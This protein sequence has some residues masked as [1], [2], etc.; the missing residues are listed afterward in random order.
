[1]EL[2]EAMA[3]L[4][5]EDTEHIR[6]RA[7]KAVPHYLWMFGDKKHRQGYCTACGMYSEKAEVPDFAMNDP[8]MDLEDGEPGQEFR[9][10]PHWWNEKDDNWEHN[11]IGSCPRC[12]ERVQYKHIGRGHRNMADWIFLCEYKKSAIDPEHT[13]CLVGY[14]VGA[15]HSEAAL[16]CE[17]QYMEEPSL[18]IENGEPEIRLTAREICIFTAGVGAWRFVRGTY[19]TADY[20]DGRAENVQ[21]CFAW[22][23]RKECKSG[24][25]AGNFMGNGPDAYLDL[26]EW[27]EAIEGTAFSADLLIP[28]QAEDY[29]DKIDRMAAMAKYPALEYMAKMGW[30][31][32]CTEIV[33]GKWEKRRLNLKAKTPDKVLKCRKDFYGWLKGAKVKPDMALI[34]TVQVAEKGG[35]RIGYE[36]LRALAGKCRVDGYKQGG[37]GRVIADMK[38][39]YPAVNAEQALK[40]MAR[41]GVWVNDYMDHL[42]MMRTL[43]MRMDESE[44]LC[45][46][47]FQKCH[48]ELSD[49]AA[50]V[51][52]AEKD[53]DAAK[54]ANE[55]RMYCFSALGYTMRPFVS[56]TEITAEGNEQHICIGTYVDKYIGRGT[57]I[58]CIRRDEELGKPFA[59][60]EFTEKDGKLVQCRGYRNNRPEWTEEEEALFWRLFEA[61]RKDRKRQEKTRRVFDAERHK[62]ESGEALTA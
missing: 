12:G 20:A 11:R 45:P 57:V 49:R 59:A 24:Y 40:Y 58:C 53:A 30:E 61:Q 18:F 17:Q 6:Q 15:V 36:K 48:G 33:L 2:E 26:T 38:S 50:Q 22:K 8:Y 14:E 62:K 19:W 34:R 55:L 1:M 52:N 13:I 32:L 9:G 29:Y 60:V 31:T 4:G 7:L 37:L 43:G 56:A 41:K 46:N 47:D 39:E 51:R 3:H 54:R 23:K 16:G 10:R 5:H 42:S 25:R 35:L 27:R 28:D 44:F 21:R